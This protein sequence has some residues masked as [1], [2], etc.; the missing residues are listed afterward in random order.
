MIYK[1]F[2]LL[3][4]RR[5][6][7]KDRLAVSF[8]SQNGIEIQEKKIYK[9]IWKWNKISSFLGLINY[10]AQFIAELARESQKDD[11]PKFWKILKIIKR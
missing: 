9:N 10:V 3:S 7:F 2:W 6:T 8:I 1:I 4:N 11:G 5:K